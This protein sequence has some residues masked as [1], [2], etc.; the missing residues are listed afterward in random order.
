MALREGRLEVVEGALGVQ[1]LVMLVQRLEWP[2]ALLNLTHLL[3]TEEMKVV[4]V[5]AAVGC[6][7]DHR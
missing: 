4:V 7:L 3:W 5:A 6:V 1:L 2:L